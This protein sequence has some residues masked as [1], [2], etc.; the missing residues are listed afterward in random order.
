MLAWPLFAVFAHAQSVQQYSAGANSSTAMA[1]VSDRDFALT[2]A[3]ASKFEV[4]EGQLAIVQA[5]DPAL[6]E[7][8]QIKVKEHTA[9]LDELRVAARAGGV[10]L[11][12]D[13]A[14]DAVHQARINAIKN[15]RGPDFDQAYR[16]D[17]MRGHQQW[18][19]RLDSYS[20]TGGNVALR[21]WATKAAALSRRHQQ[22]LQSMDTGAGSR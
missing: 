17:Q 13:I 2:A 19:A 3:I 15:R 20:Q 5:S 1:Q 12:I 10:D 8:A 9:A 18:A 16:A 7:F 14:P 6:R 22:L 4:I 21:I 11:P